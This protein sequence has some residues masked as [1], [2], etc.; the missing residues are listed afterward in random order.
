MDINVGALETCPSKI[1]DIS[2][3]N[4]TRQHFSCSIKV[5]S[6]FPL[7]CQNIVCLILC[8][9]TIGS[10]EFVDQTCPREGGVHFLFGGNHKKIP[11]W[12]FYDVQLPCD[13]LPTWTFLSFLWCCG[14]HF[15]HSHPKLDN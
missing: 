11:S 4:V 1:Q 7:S 13:W 5:E 10:N 8:V 6:W 2:C 12:S 15:C 9:V 14:K 3:Q